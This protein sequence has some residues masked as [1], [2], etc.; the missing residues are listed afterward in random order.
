MPI[1]AAIVYGLGGSLFDPATGEA[2]LVQRLKAIGVQC[3]PSPFQESDTEGVVD[4]LKDKIGTKVIIGDSL[5]ANNAP[6]FV[7]QLKEPV[8]YIA[9]F[10]PSEYG[11]HFPIPSSV[12]RAHCI[13]DP[14]WIDTGGLGYY[15][16]ELGP[17]NHTTKLVVTQHRGAHPDDWGWSQDIVFNEVKGLIK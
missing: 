4:W 16:W 14:Y 7:S 13:Y 1:Y 6:F 17:D 11:Q 2:Y 15:E 9:G 5:G 3:G 10:Q 12:G 8:D